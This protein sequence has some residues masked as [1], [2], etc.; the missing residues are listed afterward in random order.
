MQTLT[1]I[2]YSFDITD[3]TSMD[4]QQRMGKLR[5]F[6]MYLVG[7][8]YALLAQLFYGWVFSFCLVCRKKKIKTKK[9]LMFGY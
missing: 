4:Q 9:N 6:K 5:Y 1:T 8:G 7:I 2:L 3:F